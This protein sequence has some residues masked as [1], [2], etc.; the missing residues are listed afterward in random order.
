MGKWLSQDLIGYPD[1]WNNFAYCGNDVVITIDYLGCW[2]M[3]GALVSVMGD[4]QGRQILDHWLEGSGT[5]MNIYKVA[6][7]STYM[8]SNALLTSQIQNE[9]GKDA[10]DRETSGS[11]GYRKIY[12]EIQNGYTTGYEYLHGTN[13]G[14]EIIGNVSVTQTQYSETLNK[15]DLVYNVTLTWNDIIDPNY[16]YERDRILALGANW[17][18][19]PKD[20]TIRITWDSEYEFTRY[21]PIETIE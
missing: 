11:I 3:P 1:G 2:T 9:L 7:W 19:N 8:N 20:Y 17:I 12:A 4:D 16:T 6:S 5:T 21:I 10:A 18:Y 14:L 13:G 15:L